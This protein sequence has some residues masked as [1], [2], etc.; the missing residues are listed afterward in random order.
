MNIDAE[1]GADRFA[2]VFEACAPRVFAYS[3]R[4][5]E[6]SSVEDIVSE[7]F[8]VAWRRLDE[9]PADP[10]PW[11]LVVARNIMANHR[12]RLAREDQVQAGMAA[13]ERILLSTPV[14]EDVVVTRAELLA[15]LAALTVLEREAVLLTAWDGLSDRD[16]AQVAG[17]SHRAFRVRL[18][19]A[20]RRLD[21]TLGPAADAAGDDTEHG[22]RPPADA[23]RNA[24]A[25]ETR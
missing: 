23:S 3:R 12:R 14:V 21:R 7:T 5:V 10:L 4:H 15:A 13:L 2:A 20:R 25:Q 1:S 24:L 18:H 8:L 17:C 9:V 22:G 11:L 6:L 19:R 16:A